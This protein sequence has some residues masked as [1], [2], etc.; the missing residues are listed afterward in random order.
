MMN[1]SAIAAESHGYRSIGYLAVGSKR[2]QANKGR[3]GRNFM[4]P[5][6]PHRRYALRENLRFRKNGNETATKQA[7]LG[8]GMALVATMVPV[9][10]KTSGSPPIWVFNKFSL[11]GIIKVSVLLSST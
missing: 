1:I 5:G 3:T 9:T 11:K 10:S 8:S 2:F 4:L 7:V 6:A